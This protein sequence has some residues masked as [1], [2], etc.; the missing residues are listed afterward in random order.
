LVEGV[1]SVHLSKPGS[2]AV[3]FMDRARA[4]ESARQSATRSEV[5]PTTDAVRK[6]ANRP[7]KDRCACVHCRLHPQVRLSRQLHWAGSLRESRCIARRVPLGVTEKYRLSFRFSDQLRTMIKGR[8]RLLRRIGLPLT[9]VAM[10]SIAG[11]HWAALQVLAWTQMARAYSRSADVVDALIK[12]F[13]GKHPC[14]LCCKVKEGRQKEKRDPA[15]AKVSKKTEV[16]ATSTSDNLR[17]PL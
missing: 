5:F 8:G 6:P 4:N 1:E 9:Y 7:A 15:S 10:F 16:C 2:V 11:G 12:T 14:T 3:E 17:Q 13:D